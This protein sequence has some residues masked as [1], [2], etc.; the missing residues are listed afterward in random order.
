M[1]KSI[2]DRNQMFKKGPDAEEFKRMHDDNLV[3]LRKNKRNEHIAKK[4]AYGTESQT[5]AQDTAEYVD[6]IIRFDTSLVPEELGKLERRLL[7]NNLG[8]NERLNLLIDIIKNTYTGDIL[9]HAV[10]TL[11]K[12][13]SYEDANPINEVGESRVSKKLIDCMLCNDRQ[14]QIEATWCITNLSTA[15][16]LIVD[17]LISYDVV[18]A[19]V[20]IVSEGQNTENLFLQAV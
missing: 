15:Q 14:L 17:Q 13:L 5:K 18:P 1:S 9:K 20:K 19:L 6:G 11:R 2:E 16:D 8:V 10:T 4:R 7:N 12:V 3:Q